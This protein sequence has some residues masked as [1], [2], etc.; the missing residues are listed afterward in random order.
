MLLSINA[1][2]SRNRGGF[3]LIEL[4]IVVA[5]IGI[6][7]AILIPNLLDALQKSKQKR[8]VAD[9]RNLG[10]AWFSWLTDQ[11]SAAAAGAAT[12]TYNFSNL[13]EELTADDL[14]SSLYISAEMFYTRDVPE[15]DG[16]ARLY[17]YRWSG[18]PSSTPVVGIRSLGRDGVEGPNGSGGV[19]TMGPF[20][21]SDY[22]QDI[23]WADGFFVVYPSG[24]QSQ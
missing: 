9:M 23:V 16:W 4:I 7:A 24:S 3:T 21:T 14:F 18:N 8:T 1:R 17:D 6:I 5:I 20:L 2:R 11:M 12:H 15:H 13:T 10:T 19:Y 22:D